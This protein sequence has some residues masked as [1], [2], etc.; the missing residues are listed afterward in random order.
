MIE[1]TVVYSKRKTIALQVKPDGEII[2][3]APK[4][5]KQ[6]VIEH[7]VN[8]HKDWIIKA[9]EKISK[10]TSKMA[11]QLSSEQE[12]QLRESAQKSLPIL[13]QYYSNLTGLKY[14]TLKITS[15]RGRFGSCSVN[16]TICFSFRL[17]LYPKEAIEYVVLHEIAHIRYHNHSKD[18]YKYIETFMPDYKA[19]QRLL[20]E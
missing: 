11:I 10:N 17:L 4:G 3:R 8:T 15:A 1:Y 19:R 6:K 5:C 18:F 2:V 20:K 9:K 7:F 14:K 13:A 16:G 12:K